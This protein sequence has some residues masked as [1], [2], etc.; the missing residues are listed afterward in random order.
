MSL[1]S[2]AGELTLR[3]RL[4][5]GRVTWGNIVSTRPQAAVLLKG[6]TPQQAMQLAPLLFSL[7]GGAQGV[8]AQAALLAAQ[9]NMPE[10][11]QLAH[12]AG[13]VR[14]EASDEHLWHL[15]LA[16]P[17]LIGLDRPEKEYANYRQQ[18]LLA[19]TDGEHATALETIM[20][21]RLLGMPSADWLVQDHAAW[22]V[23]RESSSALGAKL[24]RRLEEGSVGNGELTA[25]C[26]PHTVALDWVD[27]EQ[28]IRAPAYC[29]TPT[30][31]GEPRETGALARQ[32]GH[33]LVEPLLATGHNIE[34]RLTARLVE[35][36]HCACGEAG[37]ARDWVDVAR[38]GHN[39]GLAR[40]EAA[41]GVLIHRVLV[42]NG[43]LSEYAI[44]APTEWNF[45]P[46]GAFAR[47]AS[48]IAEPDD[49][50]ALRKVQWLALSFDPCVVCEILL[51]HA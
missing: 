3:L 20:A 45:H 40:V 9:G 50:T 46:H 12:W 1:L 23:W 51:E 4:Q 32:H 26:L 25:A 43:A 42:E 49:A 22:T 10:A 21:S 14:R 44:V 37:S 28:E 39:I 6:K 30:W 31:L 48:R 33:A 38:C 2:L 47:E 18:C 35:L 27:R 16:W 24:L 7:C 11:E 8:A 41:R 13:A 5:R 15:M 17:K 34:A 29:S 19:R 36:A